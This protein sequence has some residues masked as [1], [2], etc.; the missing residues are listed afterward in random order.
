MTAP[1]LPIDASPVPMRARRRRWIIVALVAGVITAGIGWMYHRITER[2]RALAAIEAGGGKYHSL[3][4]GRPLIYR[5]Y[6]TITSGGEDVNQFDIFLNGPTFDD[7]WLERHNELRSIPIRELLLANTGVSRESA[8]RLL[9]RNRLTSFIVPGVPLTDA[10]AT[11]I[12]QEEGL[13]HLSLMQSQLTDAG[14]S[15]LG[16]QRLRA[17]NVAGT[18]VTSAALQKELA[19]GQLQHLL[20]DGRQFTP[21]LVGRLAQLSS[22]NAISLIGPDVTDAHLKLLAAAPN[23]T[24]VALDQTS[25]TEEAIA[26]LKAAGPKRG[27]E[28]LDTETSFAR[29]RTE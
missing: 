29:W 20:I 2:S 16:V 10:D 27:V 22:L 11:L 5:L 23:V 19:G 26:T 15:A 13:T 3:F 25:A 12:G 24:W 8:L 14:L 28:A 1:E 6:A 9:S 18:R 4:R 7:A 21:N 17:L